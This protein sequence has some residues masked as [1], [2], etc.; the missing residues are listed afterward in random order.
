MNKLDIY[1][2][3]IKNEPLLSYLK[4]VIDLYLNND[5]KEQ[6][7]DFFL[8]KKDMSLPSNFYLLSPTEKK[9][10]FQYENY[11]IH[12]QTLEVASYATFSNYYYYFLANRGKKNR[13]T[14]NTLIDYCI[15]LDE[16]PIYFLTM[17]NI[18]IQQIEFFT[19]D[20][21]EVIKYANSKQITTLYELLMEVYRDKKKD[22]IKEIVTE[23]FMTDKEPHLFFL[24]DFFPNEFALYIELLLYSLGDNTL[25]N[26]LRIIFQIY[27]PEYLKTMPLKQDAS[28]IKKAKKKF[29]EINI[30]DIQKYMYDHQNEIDN[31]PPNGYQAFYY[32][33]F[34]QE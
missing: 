26:Q 32:V 13:Q 12:P 20:N 22:N 8:Q 10:Y 7:I 28:I 5:I 11:L 16:R 6:D 25:A 9:K 4:I 19:I 21:Y 15:A 30:S 29:Q 18:K 33:F 27:K 34:C 1:Y 31:M 23:Y 3:K 24:L 2:Y 14:T 17:Q